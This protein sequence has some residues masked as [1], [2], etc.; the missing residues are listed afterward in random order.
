MPRQARKKSESGI[1]HIMFR[2]INRQSI[3]GDEED[4]ERLFNTLINYKQQCGYQVYAYCF[5]DNHIH[6]L[7]KE[8]KEELP[9][10]WK[11]IAGSYVYWYNLKYHRCGHLFQD[12]FKSEPVETDAYFLTVLR[13]IHQNPVKAGLCKAAE[14]YPY[15]SMREYLDCPILA[16]TDFALSMI[17]K[18]QLIAYHREE[19]EDQCLDVSE[20][21]RLS[22]EDAKVLLSQIT[23][24][25]VVAFQHLDRETKTAYLQKLHQTGVSIRQLSRLTGISK[26]VIERS[27]QSQKETTEPSPCLLEVK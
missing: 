18:E 21:P 5:M 23:Q 24:C 1:Y 2:G 26:K 13:Y 22:D 27:L 9:L 17:A 19:N 15:S 6:I 25:D 16:D 7:L 4:R 20:S 10:V 14:Q 11:R 12:R 8:G 3:F